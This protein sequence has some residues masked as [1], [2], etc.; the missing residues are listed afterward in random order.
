[1]R[2][3]LIATAIALAA[4]GSACAKLRVNLQIKLSNEKAKLE[5]QEAMEAR[6]NSTDRYTLTSNAGETDLLLSVSCLVQERGTVA[7]DSDVSYWPYKNFAQPIAVEAAES[8]AMSGLNDTSYIASFLMNHFINGTT[9][10]VLAE[11]KNSLRE[12]IRFF[13]AT[14]PTECKM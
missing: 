4:S 3:L 5:L 2:K 13:C 14:E 6:I 12:A 11:R 7:C 10:T 1:M 9:D 8:M